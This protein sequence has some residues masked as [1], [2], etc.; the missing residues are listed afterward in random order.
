MNNLTYSIRIFIPEKIKNRI[1]IN[2][3]KFLVQY[4]V[5]DL[6]SKPVWN[7]IYEC[8]CFKTFEKIQE[9]IEGKK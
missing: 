5:L 6:I 8:I 7:N 4:E 3:R 9:E 1:K 2:Q